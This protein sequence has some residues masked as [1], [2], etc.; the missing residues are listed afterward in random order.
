MSEVSKFALVTFEKEQQKVFDDLGSKSIILFCFTMDRAEFR[1]NVR[2]V[3][4]DVL[5]VDAVASMR[6]DLIRNER[7][8]VLFGLNDGLYLLRAEVESGHE[9]ILLRF[10]RA[11]SLYRLQR[12]L[13]FRTQVLPETRVFFRLTTPKEGLIMP[14]ELQVLDLSVGGA[15][16][17]W[18]RPAVISP[19]PGARL[20]GVLSIP[21]KDIAL[22]I[23]AVVKSLFAPDESGVPVGLKFDKLKVQDEKALLFAC[24]Q[25]H[26][27]QAPLIP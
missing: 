27:S 4:G 21:S 25:I 3:R 22:E 18:P 10:N 15:R 9:P 19:A 14:L 17:L 24:V 20:S 11:T 2:V 13:N 8:D 16:V 6:R 23:D 26:R 1:F 12:R 5:Y 7:I